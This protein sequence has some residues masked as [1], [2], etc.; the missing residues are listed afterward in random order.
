MKEPRVGLDEDLVPK[1][2]ATEQ[3]KSEPSNTVVIKEKR[4]PLWLFVVVFSL[5][6]P[7]IGLFAGYYYGDKFGREHAQFNNPVLREHYI[8]QCLNYIER[9]F[10]KM[11]RTSLETVQ[12]PS[13]PG[14]AVTASDPQVTLLLSEIKQQL[15]DLDQRLDNMPSQA[16]KTSGGEKKLMRDMAR[17]IKLMEQN[18]I[19]LV[20]DRC[21]SSSAMPKQ[22]SQRN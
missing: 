20:S 18:R 7:F 9:D 3:K 17:M 21:P 12:R 15:Q 22:L 5:P 11:V 19:E 10:K 14:A 6:L 2:E 4:S 8:G 16:V 13:A 1:F